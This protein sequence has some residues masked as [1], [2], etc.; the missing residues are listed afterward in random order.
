MRKRGVLLMSLALAGAILAGCQNGARDAGEQPAG[1]PPGQ[2]SGETPVKPV[3]QPP[4]DPDPVT[5]NLY[6]QGGYFSNTDFQLLIADP[7][8]KKYPHITVKMTATPKPLV[9]LFAAGEPVDMYADFYGNLANYADLNYLL[10]L[11]ALAKKHNFDLSRF[12][13]GALDAVRAVSGGKELWALPYNR[14]LNGLYYNKDIFDWFG[15]AYPGDGMTWSETIE[16]AQR[17]TREND[18]VKIRGLEFQSIEL[19]LLQRSLTYVNAATNAVMENLE[20]YKLAFELGKRIYSIPGNEFDP[21]GSPNGRFSGERNVAMYA[22]VNMFS[23]YAQIAELN[24]DVAQYPSFPD[25]PNIGI[26]YDLHVIAPNKNSRYTEDVMRVLEVLY[27]DEVQT[28]M[29]RKTGRVSLLKDVRFE[30]QFAQDVPQLQGKNLKS[31]FKT[32]PAPAPA[33]SK[34]TAPASGIL[35]AKFKDY[36]SGIKD[37]NT[38]LREAKEEIE[39]LIAADRK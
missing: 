30:Q 19:P 28:Q 14:N 12:D 11:T 38:A 39:K 21:A 33:F 3:E 32:R 34:Y 8:K 15:V 10:D 37:V 17:M 25:A 1:E 22:G 26:L 18:G 9:E 6:H 16:L 35:G 36:A 20:E 7:V 4:K 24:F 27:S 5:L 23:R 29:V 13:A 2:T 31:V